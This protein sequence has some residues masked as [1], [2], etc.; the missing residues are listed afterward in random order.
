[1]SD[2]AEKIRQIR[3]ASRRVET[4]RGHHVKK[5][6]KYNISTVAA[7]AQMSASTLHTRYPEEVERIRAKMGKESRV[8]RDKKQKELQACR[9]RN[10]E[11]LAEIAELKVALSSVTS[12]YAT[13][14]IRIK[15]LDA[16]QGT[17]FGKKDP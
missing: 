10:R 1:M 11:L 3:L 17:A 5:G 4:G 16:N 6:A 12:R 8:D 14:V 9:A 13:A 7:E 15:Q 2:R